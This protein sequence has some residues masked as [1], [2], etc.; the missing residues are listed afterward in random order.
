MFFK[1]SP[2]PLQQQLYEIKFF[3]KSLEK[4]ATRHKKKSVDYA[5]KC[6]KAMEGGDNATARVYASQS[7]KYTKLALR[8]TTVACRMEI[9]E[10]MV[11]D[12]LQSG[13]MTD[14]V[15]GIVTRL[16][17]VVNPA[18]VMND[19][20]VIDKLTEDL[21]VAVGSVDS[22]M[23]IIQSPTPDE[24]REVEEMMN[25]TSDLIAQEMESSPVAAIFPSVPT[26]ENKYI[27]TKNVDQF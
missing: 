12:S 7:V 4:A 15:R 27:T 22:T 8:Y 13:Q 24:N 19:I 20:E 6:K 23:D 16:S 18:N 10:S 2:P 25:F 9:F 5:K 26:V 17:S 1:N 11:N 3:T 14:I 21:Q